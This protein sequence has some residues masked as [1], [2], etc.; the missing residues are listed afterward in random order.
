[1]KPRPRGSRMRRLLLPIVL[2]SLAWTAPVR[3][4]LYYSGETYNDLP[5]RWGGFLLDQR[6]LRQAGVKSKVAVPGSMR[7]R[8]EQE[9]AR[10]AKKDKRTAD[11]SADLGALHLRL[12]EPAKALA[13]L[14]A[15][16]RENPVH[17]RLAANLGT[18]WQLNGD[19]AQ[20]A[21]A[22][23]QAVKLAPGKH[24]R[25]EQLHLRLV[26]L[27]QREKAAT[28]TLDNLFEVRY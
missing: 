7:H 1:M 19:L 20:A 18:A 27:R 5:A 12:G 6:A 4:G 9:A 22:L 17:F 25:A 16:Q 24:L 8:Y 23:A 26:R 21:A 15:A 3:A 14:R 28:Q 13:V 11:E 2:L 10:L